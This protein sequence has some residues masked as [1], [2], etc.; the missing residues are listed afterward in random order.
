MLLCGTRS[1]SCAPRPQR[2]QDASEDHFIG[3][4]SLRWYFV[5]G[6]LMLTNL[7]TEQLVGLNGNIFADGCLAGIW[8]EAG[9]SVAMMVCA[10]V[11]LP[12]CPSPGGGSQSG[13]ACACAHAGVH[14]FMS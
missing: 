12:R 7:S 4:R 9:A 3:A 13:R 8:W 11:V 5:A 1:I 14:V 2:S 6:S 10:T